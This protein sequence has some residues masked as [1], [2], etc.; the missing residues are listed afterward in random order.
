[1]IDV[2]VCEDDTKQLNEIVN[3]INNYILIEDL[4]MKLQIAS[5]DP[6]EILNY[7]ENNKINKSL[8]FLDI[9]L[10]TDINGIELAAKI[11]ERDMTSK[12]VFITTHAELVFLTFKY[13]VEAL[14]FILKD[15]PDEIQGRIIKAIDLCNE[16]FK[17][18][19]TDNE[20]YYQVK[21]AD[22]IRSIKVKDILFFESSSVPHK[23][24]IH[25][26]NGQ[27]EFYSTIKEIAHENKAFFRCYKSYVVNTNNIE[28]I[29]RHTREITMTNGE[30]LMSSVMACRSLVKLKYDH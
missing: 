25:L 21:T 30:K 24:I 8:Y 9:D 12:I 5:K 28:A 7:L 19:E 10:Q 3:Y 15:F 6:H 17:K 18:K 1:M 22:H 26:V 2:Y 23:V 14:D 13:Q 16:Q 20:E 27:F 11:R 29:N 4:E